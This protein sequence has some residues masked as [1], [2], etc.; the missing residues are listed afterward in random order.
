MSFENLIPPQEHRTQTQKRQKATLLTEKQHTRSQGIPS[1]PPSLPTSSHK[2]RVLLQVPDQIIHIGQMLAQHPLLALGTQRLAAHGTV[3]ALDL[4]A[5]GQQQLAGA[6]VARRRER[7]ALAATSCATTVAR[8]QSGGGRRRG[9]RRL[10]HEVEVQELHGLE[11]DVAGGGA[12]LEDGGHG[13][14]AVELLEGAGVARRVEEG[15]DEHEEGRGLDG[16]AVYWFEEV[17]EEL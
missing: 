12:R 4:A 6:V 2:R 11:L 14:Q 8:R 13:E 16:G 10:G 17:E 1:L 3:D 15:D 5:V 9:R 7:A